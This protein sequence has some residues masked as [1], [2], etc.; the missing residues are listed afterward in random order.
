KSKSCVLA[1]LLLATPGCTSAPPNPQIES[2]IA[3][4]HLIS[5]S[6]VP[7]GEF[8]GGKGNQIVNMHLKI[9]QAGN[10][11]SIGQ[12]CKTW[13]FSQKAVSIEQKCDRGPN[14]DLAIGFARKW[15]FKPFLINGHAEVVETDLQVEVYPPENMPKI[16]IQFPPVA[17]W[18][19]V[20]ITL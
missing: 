5:S 7:G 18:S 14:V 3:Y 6:E 10:V 8:P 2:Q 16:H 4:D 11:A 1:A 15:K 17:D 19:T 12:D 9:D 20:R 13:V